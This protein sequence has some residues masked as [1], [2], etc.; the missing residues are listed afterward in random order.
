MRYIYGNVFTCI[1]IYIQCVNIYVVSHNELYDEVQLGRNVEEGKVW[2]C[3]RCGM[4]IVQGEECRRQG[5]V[6]EVSAETIY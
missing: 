2:E 3:T 6:W 1:Y 5:K 4:Y